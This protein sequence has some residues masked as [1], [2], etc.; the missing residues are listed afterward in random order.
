MKVI[1]RTKVP[2]LVVETVGHGTFDLGAERPENFTLVVFY[3][4]QH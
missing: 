3:R 2:E 4:G 1:P